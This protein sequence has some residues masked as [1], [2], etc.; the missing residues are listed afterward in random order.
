MKARS[1]G[2]AATSPSDLIVPG[3]WTRVGFL[4]DRLRVRLLVDGREVA[5]AETGGPIES[6]MQAPLTIGSRREPMRGWVDEMRIFRLVPGE[7][8]ELPEGMS[9]VSGASTIVFR[10][11]GTLD[12]EVH[13]GPVT[14]RFRMP[15]R[16]EEVTVGLLGMIL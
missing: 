13:K 4:C 7:G 6:D 10:R 12:P 5:S 3:R 2:K 14:V 11:G 9:F 16:T 8:V 15:D 1:A